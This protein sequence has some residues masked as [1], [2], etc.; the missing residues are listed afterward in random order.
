MSDGRERI[1]RAILEHLAQSE[2]HVS[3][4]NLLGIEGFLVIWSDVFMS[5]LQNLTDNWRH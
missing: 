5:S 4:Q 3:K 2:N 1:R